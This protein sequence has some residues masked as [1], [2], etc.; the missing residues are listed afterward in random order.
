MEKVFIDTNVVIDLLAKREPFYLEAQELFS[1]GDKKEVDLYISSL[2]F[3]NAYYSV[4][5]HYKSTDTKKY[6]AK[7][8]V[9]IKV[10][11]FEDKNIELGL[12]SDFNDFEDAVQY[13]IALENECDVIVTRNK[14]DFKN[15]KIPVM[16]ADE[17]VKKR[18]FR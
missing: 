9:L 16:T 10:L 18:D 1:L 2:T 13:Y 12:T 3:A 8:K 4:A 11:N 7:F 17:F 15:S 14:K 5:K 6:M